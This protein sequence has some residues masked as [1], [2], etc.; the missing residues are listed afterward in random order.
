MS[1]EKR[2]SN[3]EAAAGSGCDR[4]MVRRAGDDE[5]LVYPMGQSI[6]DAQIMT[7]ADV[8]TLPGVRVVLPLKGVGW[9]SW[10]GP[11]SPEVAV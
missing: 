10:A 6:D 8:E 3:L 1:I 5:Y 11:S 9:E 7:R 4:W 2:I